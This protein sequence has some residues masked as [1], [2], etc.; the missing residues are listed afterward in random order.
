MIY[1]GQQIRILLNDDEEIVHRGNSYNVAI[2]H[3]EGD[4][5]YDRAII[6]CNG[7]DVQWFYLHQIKSINQGNFTTEVV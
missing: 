4:N 1:S 7:N 6:Y 2:F 3:Y 5:S